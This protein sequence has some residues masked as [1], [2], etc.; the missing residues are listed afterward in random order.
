MAITTLDGLIAGMQPPIEFM[1]IGAGTQVAG[2]LYTPMY[3]GGYPG[4]MSAPAGGLQGLGLTTKAGQIPFANPG[5][6]NTYLAR[7]AG[8]CINQGTLYLADRLWEN[9]GNSATSTG[10][11]TLSV[12]ASNITVANPTHVT[13]AAHGQAAGT[14]TVTITGS[15]S[16]PVI[17]GTYTATYVSGTEFTLPINVT[18]SGNAGVVRIGIPPR[19]G[20]GTAV[21]TS[22]APTKFGDD[23]MLAYEVSSTMGAN[24]STI[25]ANYINQDGAAKTTVSITM[26]ATMITGAF[27][28]LPLAAGDTGVRAVTDHIKGTTQTSGTYH[29]V[30]YR[31]L[32]RVGLP[33]IGT[34]NAADAVTGGMPRL[35]DNSVPFLIWMPSTTTAPTQL[36]GQVIYS[37]G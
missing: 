22:G 18:N 31:V 5:S 15:N 13:T 7:F 21:G 14:F 1:K 32:G 11:Q 24:T 20:N 34:A 27:I 19:D 12:T 23:V 29:L 37:Q 28:P 26:S 17:D 33:I 16:T 9:S 3:A 25:T 30:M 10:T 35:Y 8:E 4:A 2:R 6:G 36:S